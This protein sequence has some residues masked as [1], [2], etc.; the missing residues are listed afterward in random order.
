MNCNYVRARGP[1][2]P[3][4]PFRR[5]YALIDLSRFILV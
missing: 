4:V 2:V 1:P 3:V 5:D